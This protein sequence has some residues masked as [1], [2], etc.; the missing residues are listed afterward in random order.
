MKSANNRETPGADSNAFEGGFHATIRNF[1]AYLVALLVLGG[2]SANAATLIGQTINADIT[3]TGADDNGPY[4][5]SVFNGP[6]I[7]SGPG[8]LILNFP[9]FRQLTEDGFSTASNQITGS[10]RLDIGANFV[11][12]NMSGQVQ[13]FELESILT[14]ISGHITG[15]TD[16]ATGIIPGVNMDFSNSFTPSS[17]DFATYYLGFQPGTNVT[18]TETLTFGP[19]T[20]P[21]PAAL[22]LFATCLGALGLFGWRRSRTP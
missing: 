7:V 21:L 22:P 4:S 14:G 11:S 16:S 12:V 18:Q 6:A 15:A 17:L 9:V 8:D 5:I 3:I 19:L 10:V 1:V 2:F 13:P 20:T